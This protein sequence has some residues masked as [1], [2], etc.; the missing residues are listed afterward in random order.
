MTT[1]FARKHT[2]AIIAKAQAS[3]KVHFKFARDMYPATVE[4]IWPKKEQKSPES[5]ATNLTV[6]QAEGLSLGLDAGDVIQDTLEGIRNPALRAFLKAVVKEPEVNFVMRM[7]RNAKT[8]NQQYGV[9]CL[10]G[11]ARAASSNRL[12]GDAQREVVYAATILMGCRTLIAPNKASKSTAD[13]ILFTIVR[14][15]LHR[16][17]NTAPKQAQLLRLCLGWGNEEEMASDVMTGMTQLI[18]QSLKRAL[19]SDDDASN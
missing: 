16:L 17:D 19:K 2:E 4:Y 6:N 15:A 10:H 9:E 3:S 8:R 13:D 14:Q 5:E 18:H 7:C 12:I 11:A 1:P